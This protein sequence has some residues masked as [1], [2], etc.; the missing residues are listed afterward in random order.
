MDHIPVGTVETEITPGV[1]QVDFVEGLPIIQNLERIA[2]VCYQSEE[3]MTRDGESARRMMRTLIENGH[4]AMLEH[5]KLTVLFT[6]DRGISHELVRHR[7]ASFAQESTRYC[8]YSKGKFGHEVTFIRPCFLDNSSRAYNDWTRTIVE[9]EQRYFDMLEA[10]CKPEEARDV[11]PTSLKTQVVVTAN[12]R[13]WRHILK[14]RCAKD[15]HPQMK[16]LMIPL[17]MEL[18]R[19]IPVLFDDIQADWDWYEEF[20]GGQPDAGE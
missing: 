8:N 14:L 5:E 12:M 18:K 17:L 20:K 2:R 13:E 16:E 6:C 10:G 4:E 1:N 3:K 7:M 19:R 15:A 9:C 11:L